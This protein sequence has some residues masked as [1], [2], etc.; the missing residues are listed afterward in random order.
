MF[1]WHKNPDVVT[2]DDAAKE[3]YRWVVSWSMG[4]DRMQ[5]KGIQKEA[6]CSFT[7]NEML[8]IKG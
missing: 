2:Q 7:C 6:R 4:K 8:L 3:T 1:W 5:K